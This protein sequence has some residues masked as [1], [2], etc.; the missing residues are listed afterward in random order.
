MHCCENMS[1]KWE[2]FYNKILLANINIKEHIIKLIG[3]KTVPSP[4]VKKELK[5]QKHSYRPLEQTEEQHL[6]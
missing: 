6:H 1:L 4:S 2:I 5:I 3:V